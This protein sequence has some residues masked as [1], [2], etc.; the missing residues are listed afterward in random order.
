[1]EDNEQVHKNLKNL[2][3]LHNLKT[4]ELQLLFFVFKYV[5]KNHSWN[6]FAMLI[7]KSS[8]KVLADKGSHIGYIA[9]KRSRRLIGYKR[10][11]SWIFKHFKRSTLDQR[12]CSTI[13]SSLYTT[14][15][16]Y[17]SIVHHL[18]CISSLKSG[19]ISKF[20]FQ[21]NRRNCTNVSKN[22]T[23]M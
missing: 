1:M 18:F 11:G 23:F 7:L 3:K 20:S 15:M 13:D 22:P 6:A 5:V 21:A 14:F 17:L 12:D 2:K 4:E 16:V 10:L 19:F 8:Q 9:D